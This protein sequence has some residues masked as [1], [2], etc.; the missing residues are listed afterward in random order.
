MLLSVARA[1]EEEDAA[2]MATGEGV[3]GQWLNGEYWLSEADTVCA[4]SWVEEQWGFYDEAAECQAT[5][6]NEYEDC[7]AFGFCSSCYTTQCWVCRQQM[8]DTSWVKKVEAD[9]VL[10]TPGSVCAAGSAAPTGVTD[11]AECKICP[12]GF[13]APPHATLC[14][15]CAVGKYS[16]AVN[17]TECVVC[18][19]KFED[20]CGDHG[21]CK[22]DGSD[23]LSAMAEIR[24][25]GCRC[26]PGWE[27]TL[28]DT[29][30][31]DDHSRFIALAI[32]G[33]ISVVCICRN[34]YL[35]CILEY[36]GD[37]GDLDVGEMRTHGAGRDT[38]RSYVAKDRPAMASGSQNSFNG[39]AIP[40]PQFN[41]AP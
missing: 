9:V 2:P 23:V 40:T 24:A 30:V 5:C 32:F 25:S 8:S 35:R 38:S 15:E 7:T 11:P 37:P 4:G 29:E 27:G 28:C 31:D 20:I 18:P 1:D 26:K 22:V 39:V 12:M 13:W 6:K 14:Y 36:S 21:S 17:Q 33:A 16:N 41:V 19:S 3:S 10:Y 34:F